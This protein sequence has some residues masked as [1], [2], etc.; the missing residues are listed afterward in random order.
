M[1]SD[2]EKLLESKNIKITAN[3][4]LILEYIVKSAHSLSI[5]D[6]EAGLP[7][8]DRATIFRTLKTFEENALLHSIKDDDKSVKYALCSNSCNVHHHRIHPHFHCE[9]CGN[10]YCLPAHHFQLPPLPENYTADRYSLI[11]NGICADC[12]RKA[13]YK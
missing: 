12:Q 4:L 7:W 5:A 2:T 9:I 10:T 8:A 3:R 6:I 11:I 13:H 1:K